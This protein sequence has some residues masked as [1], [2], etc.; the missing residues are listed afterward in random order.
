MVSKFNEIEGGNKKTLAMFLIS[1]N[2]NNN[3]V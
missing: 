3:F 2:Y 1:N